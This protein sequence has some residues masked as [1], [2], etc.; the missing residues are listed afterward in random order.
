MWFVEPTVATD[1][2]LLNT[3]DRSGNSSY[4]GGLELGSKFQEWGENSYTME[5]SSGNPLRK[6]LKRCSENDTHT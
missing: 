2:Q 6:E 1:S 3:G 5:I 4:E